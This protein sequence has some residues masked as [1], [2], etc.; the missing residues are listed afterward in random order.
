MWFVS[1]RV[2]HHKQIHQWIGTGNAQVGLPYM[3]TIPTSKPNHKSSKNC[4]TYNVCNNTDLQM[5]NEKTFAFVVIGV[6]QSEGRINE[7]KFE[8]Y[9]EHEQIFTTIIHHNIPERSKLIKSGRYRLWSA[10]AAAKEIHYYPYTSHSP[11]V[12]RKQRARSTLSNN[13]MT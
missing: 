8:Q 7:G 13:D 2:M 1:S 12:N 3:G 4:L 11:S 10:I 6:T 5:Y 9:I